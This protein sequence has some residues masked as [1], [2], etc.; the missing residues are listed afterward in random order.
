MITEEVCFCQPSW[1]VQSDTVRMA[2]THL[3]AHMAPVEFCTDGRDP[4]QPYY[5]SPWQ[6]EKHTVPDGRSEAILRGDFFCLPFGHAEREVGTPS[7]GNTAGARWSLE[8]FQSRNGVHELRVHMKNALQSATVTRQFFLRDEENVI[9]DQTTIEGLEGMYT[10]GHHAVLRVPASQSSLLLSTSRQLY[11][12]THPNRSN[13]S[14]GRAP[15]L[16]ASGASFG[17][18][19]SVPPLSSGSSNIDCSTYP[20]RRG[21]TDLLQIGVQAEKG[22]PAWT[23]TVNTDEG[24][25]WF[26]LRNQKLLPSTIVWMENQGRSGA[27][28]NSRN[29][30]LGLEDVCSYFDT[31]SE[32]SGAANAFSDRGI[33]TVQEF[34]RDVAL[35]VPYVQGTARIPRG[36]ARVRDVHCDESSAT[37]TDSNGLQISV[38]LFTGFLFGKEL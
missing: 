14:E 5:V 33:K 34:R 25:L 11:G 29:C 15:H 24:Y 32:L 2:I 28:W 36:F 23:A 21:F 10:F 6:C 31:G 37:F 3:G 30:S 35:R 18:I 9:Y 27:P 19:N 17:A 38:S 1:V 26:S 7:H 12:M 8:G 13:N 22:Q 16:L 20:S 4:V